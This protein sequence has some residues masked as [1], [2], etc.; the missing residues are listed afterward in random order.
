MHVKYLGRES[1]SSHMTEASYRQGSGTGAER[2]L[3][4]TNLQT[5]D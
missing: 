1:C 2:K 3:T 4:S 5:A